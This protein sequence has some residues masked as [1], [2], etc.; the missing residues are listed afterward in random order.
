MLFAEDEK[1]ERRELFAEFADPKTFVVE[2]DP[3]KYQ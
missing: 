1:P 2:D 3:E